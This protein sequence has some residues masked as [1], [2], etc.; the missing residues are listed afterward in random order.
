MEDVKQEKDV[1]E[2]FLFNISPSN[3]LNA[4]LSLIPTVPP[5]DILRNLNVNQMS[6]LSSSN[7]TSPN[8]M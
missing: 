8:R 7:I 4:I 3:I 2:K 1:L 5:A 6:F